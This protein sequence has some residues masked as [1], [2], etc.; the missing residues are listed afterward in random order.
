MI[1]V[2]ADVL[3]RNRTGE[4][5]YVLNLL[6]QLPVVAPDLEVAA[7]TRRPD[8]VPAGVQPIELPARSQELRMAWTLPRLLRRLKPAVAHFQHALPLGFGGPSVLTLHDLHFERDPR[9]MG[10]VDR[11]TFKTVVPRSARRADRVLAVSERTKQ[12]AI[13]LYGLPTDKV[14]VT[15][16]GVDPAFGPVGPARDGGYLLFVGAIQARK[17]P[18]AA[19]EAALAVGRPLVVVGPEKDP[20]LAAELRAGG[21]DVRGWVAQDELA[22]LYRGA[23]A[24]VLPSRFEGFGIPVLEAMASGTPVVLSDDAALREV[25]G[26]AGLYASGGDFAGPL[27]LALADRTHYARAGLERAKLFSWE[28]T[29]RLTA[30]AYRAVLA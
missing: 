25:A 18:R 5:T 1:V 4:E 17:D 19:L 26:P 8:L 28:E 10:L 16:H 9:V 20:A 14:V 21:A 13:E 3:G 22:A 27:R 12:D 7:I 15:P 24:L 6:R 23:A 30:A 29:A 11:I 2:D